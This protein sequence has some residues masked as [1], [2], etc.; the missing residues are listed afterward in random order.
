MKKLFFLLFLLS[1][2]SCESEE[3]VNDDLSKLQKENDSLRTALKKYE[4]RYVYSFVAVRQ[5]PAKG[6][7][8]IKGSTYKGEITFLPTNKEDYI[9]FGTEIKKRNNNT[10]II[11]PDTLKPSKGVYSFETKL[12][13]DT[14]RIYFKPLIQ[15]DLAL[16]HMN[17]FYNELSFSD[18]IIVE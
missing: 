14:T 17:S 6:N 5:A 2:I 7:T 11:D 9:L 18:I 3:N 12:I 10:E 4:E 15:N 16:V 8:F 13:T 1:I